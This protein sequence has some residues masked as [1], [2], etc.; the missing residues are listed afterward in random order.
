MTPGR[1]GEVIRQ[2]PR[3]QPVGVERF[4]GALGMRRPGDWTGR[5]E[6]LPDI[7]PINDESFVK[8]WGNL[9]DEA[10]T[11][12][13]TSRFSGELH[14]TL[15]TGLTPNRVQVRPTVQL[16]IE[17]GRIGMTV[18]ADLNELSGH[19]PLTEAELPEGIHVTQVSGDGLMDWTI[20]ADHHLHLIW[21]RPGSGPRR[22]VRITGWVPLSEGPLRVGA[23]PHRARIP[24]IGWGVAEAATGTLLITSN[25]KVDLQGA[26]GL[27]PMPPS[28]GPVSAGIGGLATPPYS[29]AYQVNDPSRL[30]EILLTPAARAS[31]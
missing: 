25:V 7:V 17:S 26:A 4:I 18:N 30:G 3:I 23:R 29:L 6:P 1:S 20:S 12:S 31:P 16:R 19:F 21:Q 2:I 8:A 11:L 13:G 15:R 22:H 10:L 27:T 24:W 14:A 9:P 5:L 28:P